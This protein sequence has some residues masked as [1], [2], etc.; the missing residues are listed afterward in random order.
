MIFSGTKAE[1]IDIRTYKVNRY[2]HRYQQGHTI[3][4]KKYSVELTKQHIELKY[5]LSI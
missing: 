4:S 1:Q 3:N 2:L 5:L